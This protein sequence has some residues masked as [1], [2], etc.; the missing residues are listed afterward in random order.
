LL[1][2]IFSVSIIPAQENQIQF[3]HLTINEGLSSSSIFSIV[4]D[5]TGF[6]WFAT[7]DGLNRYDGYSFTVYRNDPA[8]PNSISDFGYRK[9]F[10]DRDGNLWIISLLGSIDKY[11]PVNDSFLHYKL[12]YPISENPGL[13][14][15]ITE[16]SQGRLWVGT[17][18]GFLFYYDKK[19]NSFNSGK[20]NSD[21]LKFLTGR[22]L[23]NIIG[24]KSGTI[25]LGTWEGLLSYDIFSKRITVYQ[26]NSTVKD[27]VFD[28]AVDKE[29]KL[30]IATV[31]H[32]IKYFDKLKNN[33]IVYQDRYSNT[34]LSGDKN[35]S[36]FCD[37][38][39]N[40]WIGTLTNGLYL[41]K[42]DSKSLKHFLHLPSAPGSLSNG[43]VFSI[44][45]DRSGI[46]WIGNY[47]GGI[48]YFHPGKQ[49]FI[50]IVNDAN[51]SGSLT[52]NSV[53]AVIESKDKTLWIGTDGG[54]LN[55]R[56]KGQNNFEHF[57][58]KP[59][60]FG[61]STIAAIAEDKTGN[62]WMGTD[63]NVN[64]LTGGLLKYEKNKNKFFPIKDI[65]LSFGGVTSLLVDS[66][67]E[68]W[69]GS[70]TDG[71]RRYN[72]KTGE[73]TIYKNEKDN[74][75]CLSGNSVFALFEDK[76]RNIWVGTN[77]FG[78][79]KFDKSTGKFTWFKNNP[80]DNTSISG[81]GILC[82]AEDN[83]GNLW[84]GTNG[85][86]F[87]KFMKKEG[88]F[89]SFTIDD[90][91]PGNSINGIITDDN[92]NLWLSTNHGICRF[93]TKTFKCKNFDLSDGLQF[94]EFC[95]GAF[96]KGIDGTVYF[97]GTN[98]IVSF[99]PNR[100]K[101]NKF[102]PPISFTKFN[103]FDS[104]WYSGIPLNNK[105]EIILS[106][107]Q[108]FFSFEFSVLD[109][110]ASD[111][112]RYKYKLEGIDKEW[113]NAG[114]RRL[115]SYTDIIPGKYTF[116]VKG[117]NSD[118][119]WS[120]NEAVVFVVITPP[121]WQTWWFRAL[122][123]LLIGSILYSL[124]LFRLNKLLEIERTRI[125][126]ARDLHD[127]VSATLTG[128]T[129]FSSA[130]S[131]EIGEQK[132]PMLHK[133]LSLIQEST[134]EVQDSMSDIIW[135][136]NPQNDKWDV[137]LPKFR[138]FASDLLESKGIK[139]QI[140]IP[141]FMDNKSL[142]MER[143]RNLWLIFKEMVTNTVKHSEC[144]EVNIIIRIENKK[145]YLSVKDDG[146]GFDPQIK[147]DRNG[148]KNIKDRSAALK[149]ILNLNSDKGK[150]TT[151][152]LTIPI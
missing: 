80:K 22:H 151:W 66:E 137:I 27:M 94:L 93:N 71:L 41:L 8:N 96:F 121:F 91:L 23:Q 126:I 7:E 65:K 18:K 32:G 44:Y 140:E 107:K 64:S 49:N 92:D 106:Y 128:I 75:N 115:A 101:E 112:N 55:R 118:G 89:K 70:N 63:I 110:I 37:S 104:V 95:T 54:G 117:C 72:E 83:S 14:V 28:F 26:D 138:R 116:R 67:N 43:S 123:F 77:I 38:H 11:N 2:Y 129:Y 134:S 85:R 33:F 105:K 87:N 76:E 143:R 136:I 132:T 31:N 124:H 35:L 88:Q 98:G 69:I 99:H 9:L 13:P 16:D 30:W 34:D 147:T 57:F 82:I 102:I 90:G 5:R 100:I 53:L 19:E 150:G 127:E 125:R 29:D 62:I 50:N 47:N 131:N 108:N 148:L 59:A 86:G 20:F 81:D 113:I 103:V 142:P 60:G 68:I 4:Q 17:R 10:I 1:L 39:S 149:G 122:I 6:M 74:V 3:N 130:I 135:S 120:S 52:P 42:P 141:E 133:L 144:R 56:N 145:L 84:I 111:K 46:I 58:Q 61:S 51:N 119:I 12:K 139:Y 152:E 73:V 97:G 109:F 146:K 79:N 21:D 25:W 15:S 24:D 78:L 45:E 40:I 48:N 36:V 114:N